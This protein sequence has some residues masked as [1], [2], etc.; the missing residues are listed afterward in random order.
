[1]LSAAWRAEYFNNPYLAGTPNL[2]QQDASISFNWGDDA[3][4]AGLPNDNFSVRWGKGGNLTAGTYRFIVTASLGFRL[5]LDDVIILDTWDGS[6]DGVTIG[7]DIFIDAGYHNLQLDY[8][9]LGEDAYI[10]LDWGLAP[11]GALA[12]Q[13]N[14]I[15]DDDT[16]SVIA[17]TLNV[18]SEARIANNVITRITRGQQFDLIATSADGRWVQLDLGNG[19][20]GWV[21]ALYVV[22][23][24]P[25]SST[26]GLEGQTLRSNAR[27]LVRHSPLIRDDNAIN[28]L[29]A[30]EDAPV[31][32]RS[33]DG[34]WWQIRLNG[35]I[36]WVNADFVTL[37]PDFDADA[38]PI[39]DN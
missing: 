3:P 29:L 26:L 19:Q 10:Y 24:R 18:R 22:P 33:S 31:I 12:P 35:Q 1:M 8:H 14:T 16:V 37:A 4:V 27:L 39:I 38:V 13:S 15:I 30:G 28:V 9:N 2:I 20:Q 21:S 6:A 17:N 25:I 32:G 36:G 34:S 11:S 23:A 7:R 5:Y